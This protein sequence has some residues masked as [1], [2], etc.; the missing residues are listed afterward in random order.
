VTAR[1]QK[2]AALGRVLEFEGPKSAIVFCRTRL[3]VDSLTETL[4]AYGYRVQA[5]HGGMMQR[6]RDRVMQ[7]FRDGKADLLVATDV[8][9]RGLDIEHLSHVINYDV[10][11]AAEAYVHRIGRTGRIGREGVAITLA[12]PREHRLLKNIEAFTKQKIE[13]VPL[14]TVNDLQARRLEL[15]RAS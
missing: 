6:Q 7:L 11:S 5:L 3:E 14:P 13:I 12:E 1:N 8:A 9:A 4:D 15:T 10:P 2:A